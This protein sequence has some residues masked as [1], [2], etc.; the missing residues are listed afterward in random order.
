MPTDHYTSG[1]WRLHLDTGGW[2]DCEGKLRFRR[3]DGGYI[4][5]YDLM[6]AT[7]PMQPTIDHVIAIERRKL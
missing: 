2:I 1:S 7:L 5:D 3:N 6:T 4:L